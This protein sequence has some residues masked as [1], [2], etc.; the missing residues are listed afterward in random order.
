M[1]FC[2]PIREIVFENRYK[3]KSQIK[4]VLLDGSLFIHM[5]TPTETRER[6]VKAQ[7]ALI[8]T[9]LIIFSQH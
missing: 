3:V 2:K 9:M 7:T 8:I 5:S 6:V 4:N 1:R